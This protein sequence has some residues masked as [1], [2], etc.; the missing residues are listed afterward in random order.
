[1]QYSFL[2]LVATIGVVHAQD[3][4]SA[5]AAQLLSV[6]SVLQTA[7]PSSLIQEALTNSAGVSSELASQF[8][9]GETPSW[10]T[11]LPSDVQTYL[12][13]TG[14]GVPSATAITTGTSISSSA[15]GTG[16]FI[17]GTNA[18]LGNGTS[19]ALA[20]RTSSKV[21]TG[22][23]EGA[24]ESETGSSS[25]TS[26]RTSASSSSTSEAGAGMP[27]AAVA[28]GFAGLAGVVGVLAL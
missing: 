25:A 8:A 2:A 7:L 5:D 12:V 23:T 20:S 6:V 27:T 11:A 14:G 26:S 9:A 24:T 28:M 18:T 21:Q 15:T 17:P 3:D 4:S 10:F 22:L 16:G 19:T 1:M 13:P